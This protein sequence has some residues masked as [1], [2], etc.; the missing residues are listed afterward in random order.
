MTQVLPDDQVVV[1]IP[2]GFTKLT[3]RCR[4]IKESIVVLEYH[5][6][7]IGRLRFL[8]SWVVKEQFGFLLVYLVNIHKSICHK[9][10]LLG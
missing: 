8:G 4:G 3:F 6:R 7:F 5:R 9:E 10:K 1:S 2:S